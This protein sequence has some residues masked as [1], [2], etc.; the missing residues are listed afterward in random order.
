V[1]TNRRK[2]PLCFNTS[3]YQRAFPY[4]TIFG[5]VEFSYLK[6]RLCKTVFVDPVPSDKILEMM[7]EKSHY[8]DSCY[9]PHASELICSSVQLLKRFLPTGSSVL[10]FGCGTGHFLNGLLQDGFI[11]K[12]VEFD[13]F[14]SEWAQRNAGCPV[15][16][17]DVF[18][19]NPQVECVDAVHLGDVLEHLVNPAKTL[20]EIA[21]RTPS[22]CLFFIEGPLEENASIV[23]WVSKFV[24]GLKRSLGKAP[25]NFPPFH[26][27]RANG[28]TQLE[29]LR[30]VLAGS[31]LLYW[32]VFE[33]GWPY[34][35][36]GLRGRVG[37]VARLLSGLQV[38]NTQFGNR[39]E[40]V[41][42]CR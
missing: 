18:L 7:Y 38:G 15:V 41:L 39:F 10:D 14:S 19:R 26:L 30:Q 1:K 20:R 4:E 40:A 8:H 34:I 13:R 27:T 24:G 32:R 16:T 36:T 29:F 23:C 42:R 5:G 35:G 31:E 33:T 28:R 25:G 6:C 9:R 11:A 2:C 21:S 12:G 37:G 22:G 17:V 3:P